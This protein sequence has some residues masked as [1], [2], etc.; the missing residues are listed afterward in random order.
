MIFHVS[1]CEG[2]K[3]VNFPSV[4]PKKKKPKK[5]TQPYAPYLVELFKVVFN[6]N[7][8][9]YGSHRLMKFLPGV[10]SVIIRQFG[11]FCERRQGRLETGRPNGTSAP[12]PPVWHTEK[13]TNTPP[14]PGRGGRRDLRSLRLTPAPPTPLI[15]FDT[16]VAFCPL[17]YKGGSP[18]PPPPSLSRSSPKNRDGEGYQPAG[19]LSSAQIR[20]R[21]RRVCV[22][23]LQKNPTDP[24]CLRGRSGRVNKGRG[25]GR[26]HLRGQRGPG[27]PR[28]HL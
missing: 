16:K 3:A 5:P 20:R 13:V 18:A 12:L 22:S 26:W 21:S 15:T 1:L 23:P 25:R 27:P 8:T 17:A 4:T 9:L 28:T 6:R 11:S 10:P 24:P 7:A 2:P 19:R 14:N